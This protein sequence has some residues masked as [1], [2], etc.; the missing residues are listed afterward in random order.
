MYHN[1]GWASPGRETRLLSEPEPGA[2]N[3]TAAARL[4][5]LSAEHL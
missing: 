3:P 4:L 1:N 2:V 5:L